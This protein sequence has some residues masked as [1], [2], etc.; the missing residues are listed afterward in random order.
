[1]KAIILTLCLALCSQ[2][3]GQEGQLL[4]QVEIKGAVSIS[5]DR[6]GSIYISDKFG[7]LN[8][9]SSSGDLELT[10][11]TPTR[12]AVTLLEAWPTLNVLLFYQDFQSITL[13]NRFLTPIAD[14]DLNGKVGFARLATFNFES[15]I[16]I[17]DDSDFTLKLW[18]RQRDQ[19]TISTP[20]NLILNPD[21]YDITFMREYQNQLFISDRKSGILIFDNLGNYL[22]TLPYEDVKYFNF[23]G[24][25]I[26]FMTEKKL[27]YYNL[28][29]SEKREVEVAES[30]FALHQREGLVLIDE[31][32]A[33]FYA[34]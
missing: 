3:Y 31:N 1:M 5:Q 28:Y 10:F 33:N 24:N 27:T 32:Q 2:S 16:W 17:V 6:N 18:D 8:R 12:G 13:L 30:K 34:N 25:E 29:S 19:I 22:R 15:N 11:S 4:R 20:F 23:S 9:Y 21:N 14:I 7:T 26:Y